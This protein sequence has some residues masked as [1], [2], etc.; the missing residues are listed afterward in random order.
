MKNV[1]KSRANATEKN[2]VIRSTSTKK[3][4]KVK[5][6]SKTKKVVYLSEGVTGKDAMKSIYSANNKHKQD[7]GTF[8]FCLRRALQFNEFEGIIAGFNVEEI[9][10]PKVLIPLR[11]AKNIGKEKFS[12]YEVLMLIKK[13]YQTK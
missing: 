7:F 6:V 10:N 4:I 11:S 5:K 9:S 3:A 12:V 2:V 8:S 1:V 13:Y